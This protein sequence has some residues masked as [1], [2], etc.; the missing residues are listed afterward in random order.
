MRMKRVCFHKLSVK[1]LALS[2]VLFFPLR[3]FAVGWTPSDAGLVVDLQLGDRILVSVMADP[4]G[5]G[6]PTEY[7]LSNYSAYTGGDYGY[8]AGDYMKLLPQA[9]GAVEPSPVTV[10]T[11][12]NL[13]PRVENSVDYALGGTA[14]SMWSSSNKTLVTT[15]DAYMFRG[16]LSD[17]ENKGSKSFFCDVVFVVP[18]IRATT[19]FDPNNT[20][21]HGAAFDGAT[22]VGFAGMVYREV[23]MFD[24]P[25]TNH[26]ITYTNSAMVTFNTANGNR[27]FNKTTVEKGKAYYIY[28][29]TKHDATP[30]TVFRLYILNNPHNYCPDSYFFAYN[31]QSYK[32]YRTGDPTQQPPTLMT[33]S[34]AGSKVYMMDRLECMEQDAVDGK[35]FKTRGMHVPMSDSVYYYVGNR[36]KYR[37]SGDAINLGS[38]TAVS[39]F[40]RI[41]TLLVDALKGE[42]TPFVAPHGAFGKMVVDTTSA[43]QNLGVTFE[44]AGYFLR[45]NTGMNVPMHKADDGSWICDEMWTIDTAYYALSIKATL[46]SGPTFSEMDEGVDIEGWSEMQSGSEIRVQRTGEDVLNKSGWA[47]IEPGNAAKNGGM[48]FVLADATKSI[49]YDYNGYI[50][51]PLPDQYPI[52]GELT[53]KVR[54]ARLASGFTFLSWNTAADGSGAEYMPGDNFTLTGKDTLYAQAEFNENMHI[55]ISFI[56]SADS[57]RY[58]LT[59]PNSSVPRFARARHFE[60]W[61]NVRQGM[62]GPENSDPN[63]LSTFAMVDGCLMC[64]PNDRGLDPIRDTMY[65][66]Q[67]SLIYYEDYTPHGSEYLGLYYAEPNTV[68]ANNT[69]AGMFGS[70]AG[71]PNFR[72]PDIAS[73]K[74]YSERYVQ[75]ITPPPTDGPPI[76]LNT[77]E[78]EKYPPYVK[79]D[80]ATNQFN[81]V[82]EAEATEFQ[83]SAVS[84]ADAHYVILPDTTEAWRD[85]LTFGYHMN[86]QVGERV[87]SRLIGKQLMACTMVGSDTVYFHPNKNKTITD[88]NGLRLSLDYRISESFTLIPDSRVASLPGLRADD[89]VMMIDEEYNDFSRVI[90]CGVSSPKDV[91]YKG[92]Y[93][94]IY[95][96]LRIHLRPMGTSKIKE[97]YGRWKTGAEGLHV[98]EDGSRYRDVIICTKTYHY[99]P[100]E[101]KLVLKPEQESYNFSPLADQSLQ[102]NFK[103]FEVTSHWLL[104]KDGNRIVEEEISSVDVT[105]EKLMLGPGY[106]TLS[107]GDKFEV[108]ST[109]TVND[110]VVIKTRTDNDDPGE[111]RAELLVSVTIGDKADSVQVRVPLHQPALVGNDLIWSAEYN[112]QRYF[113]LASDTGLVFRQYRLNNN[114][115]YKLNTSTHLKVGSKDAKNSDI[116]YITQWEYTYTG[117]PNQLTLHAGDPINTYF[118]VSGDKPTVGASAAVLTWVYD[119]VN[120]NDNANFEE[121]VRL[122]YGADKWLAFNVVSGTPKLTL[123]NDSASASIF[124]WGYLQL[125]YSLMNNGAYPSQESAVFSFDHTSNVTIQTRYKAYKEYSILL[126]NKINYLGRV[127]QTRI[128]SLTSESREW[129]TNYAITLKR[130]GRTGAGSSGISISTDASTLTTTVSHAGAI[131]IYGETEG[132][133][134]DIVDILDVRISLQDGAKDYRFKDAWRNYTSLEDAHLEI[135]LI[136]KTYHNVAYDSL[137]CRVDNDEYNYTFPI[138]P[139]DDDTLHTF[140]LHTERHYG[141]HVVD[142][143]GNVQYVSADGTADLTSTM[144]FTDADKGE[145]RLTDAANGTPS[146]CS[147]YRTTANTITVKCKADAIR[148]PRTAY[149]YLAYYVNDGSSD[150]L[151]SF[152][153]SISQPSMFDYGYNQKLVHSR[154]ASGDP[155]MNGMQQVHENK[156]ILYY[157]NTP[158]DPSEDPD[159]AVELP[160]RER[161]FFGWWRWFREGGAD[162][163]DTDIPDALWITP[164]RNVDPKYNFPFRTIGDSVW[165]DKDDEL[166]G[167]KLVTMGR[168]TVF[169]YPSREYTNAKNDPPAKTPTVVPPYDKSVV[170]YAV[171]LSN[172]YDN[173]PLQM[174]QVNQVDWTMLDTMSSIVEPTLSL[175]EV[176]ELHPWTEMAEKM[177][178]YKYLYTSTD[179]NDK[180]MED[181]VVMAPTGNAL[182][183][184]TEHRY[185]YTNLQNGG[186]SESLLCYY[187]RDDNWATWAGNTGRQD[188]MV[189]VAG[190]DAEAKWYTYTPTTGYTACNYKLTTGDDFLQVPAKSSITSGKESDTI[191]YC[192]RARSKRT[193]GTLEKDFSD[194]KSV[195]GDSVYNICRY[196]VI[197]HYP[198]KYGPLQETTTRGVT[199]A[200]I[201][202][203]EI[204]KN[205]EV[206]ERLNF[207]YNRPGK[208]Y[209]VYPHPLPWGDASYGYSYPMTPELPDNRHHNDF[210][211]NFPN[212][213]EYG[214]I[215]RIP[216]SKF[217]HMME[218]HGGAENGYM[219]YCDGMS[220]AG[221]V[222]AISLNTKLCEGQ[223]MYF[224]GYVGNPSNQENSNKAKPNFLFSVQG[225]KDGDADWTDITSYMTGDIPPSNKWSQIFF[226]ISSETKFDHYRVRVMNMASSFDGNDFI[227]DDMCIFATKT[228]LIAYQA[229]S[230]CL[231]E[232]ESESLSHVVLRIDYQ[233]FQDSTTFNNKDV[234]Y[235]VEQMTK[236]S[237][238]SYVR[239]DDGY[240]NEGTTKEGMVYGSIRM[241]ARSHEPAHEDSIYTNLTDMITMFDATK[242][243][244][245]K[246]RQ[247]YIFENLDGQVRPVLYVVHQASVT[248]A[249]TY[250]VRMAASVSELTSS[251][252]AMTSDMKVSNRMAL[253]LNGEE[254]PEKILGGQCANATYDLSLRVKGSLLIDSVAPVDINGS[255]VNDWLL[256]GDTSDVTSSVR[257]GYKYSDIKKIIKILRADSINIRTRNANQFARNL[258]EVSRADMEK[259]EDILNL[260]LSSG[261]NA[262]DALTS[263]VNNGFLTLYQSKVTATAPYGDSIVYVIFPI[264]GTGSDAMLDMDIE[265]CPTPV[266]VK[267][268]TD[269]GMTER[270][271]V[272][273]GE[274]RGGIQEPFG[275]LAGAQEANTRIRIP[276]ESIPSSVALDTIILLSTNDPNYL[277]EIHMLS[278]LPDKVWIPGITTDRDAYYKDGDIIQLD[279]NPNN[280]YR[281]QPGYKY[282]F[283]IVMQT[284]GGSRTFESTSCEV[285]TI[286]FTV[287]VVPDYLRWDPKTDDSNQWNNPDN[288][289]G[290]TQQNAPIHEDAHFVPLPNT[291]VVIAPLAEGLPYPE[292]ADSASYEKTSAQNQ[293]GFRFNTCDSIRFMPGT[294]MRDQQ[295]LTYNGA[296]VDM[297]TPQDKWALR[298]APVMGMLSG[299]VFMSNADLSWGTTPWEVGEFDAN[300]RNYTTGNASFWLSLYRSESIHKGNGDNVKDDTT[301]TA[302]AEW[303][304]VTNSMQY[305]LKPAQGWAVYTHTAS[306]RDAVVR[307]PKNDDIY[308]YY[309]ADGE[310]MT[311][312]YEQYVRAKRASDAGGANKAGRL[313]FNPD[314]A[315][316]TYTLTNGAASTSFV[317]GNPT[318]G[319]IDIWGF[320]ADN[321]L[322]EEF[323]YIEEGAEIGDQYTT[324][325][326]GALPSSSDVITNPARYLPPMR[327]IV[328]NVSSASTSK[329]ITLNKNRVITSV[330]QVVRDP[331][332]APSR[333]S[334]T[335]LSKGIMTITAINPVST[336]CTSRLL[337]GQGFHNAVREG[338]DAMLTTINIDHY[339]TTSAPATPFNIYA[340][341]GNYGLSIDLRD[342]VVNVPISFY[343]SELPFAPTTQLWFT[344]VS[345]IDGELVLYD[346]LTGTERLLIDGICLEIPTPEYSHQT[347]YY[348]R[349]R[350]YDPDDTTGPIA[351]DVKIFETDDESAV[352]IIKD[353]HVL[354]LR[355][356]HVYTLFGQKIQ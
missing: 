29:D 115:L 35:I 330:S 314:G 52:E 44:P 143:D 68:I 248:P 157:Y 348:I 95:D 303:A 147:I 152:R 324:I 264:V 202:N 251:I 255:C 279:P 7:F 345:N 14:Y 87:W 187:M 211:S 265:V 165:I 218:Q 325:T 30:R 344:G 17:T 190:W 263:L 60:D 281:M 58:F 221:Q 226:P 2:F 172:Y 126:A 84:V 351:T 108:S 277:E 20:L 50:G 150:R 216:Y 161:G 113:I 31:E 243:S 78:N 125:E 106:C 72:T 179:K 315:A 231:S 210:A 153:L 23:Y 32:K 329:S 274:S 169:H 225:K 227:I 253:E 284:V 327:A 261:V 132:P 138:H 197:Y 205:Y 54:D 196:K 11:I 124:S 76:I 287:S 168:Y 175:R 28:A 296:V 156:R 275:I 38:D 272:L 283:G 311:E 66:G 240:F 86:E 280:T 59:H 96:T 273:H 246:F 97:Y 249:N 107:S 155:L 353:G 151:V 306:E 260:E 299:D 346:A 236:D 206:L 250:T 184:R 8:T 318:M 282:T 112:G 192:L 121:R 91:Q 135:P 15:G 214:L 209:Q 104:D 185:N 80:P 258:S 63:Y 118:A 332:P 181:H 56:N 48:S 292:L 57:M 77:R 237:V 10:W 352:K 82:V 51:S 340:A 213:G 288:W 140:V 295:L 100:T 320:I 170:T 223:K 291:S 268:K 204:E 141:S 257:Y 234:Y 278:L 102:L 286:P 43:E 203:E 62:S 338:E 254:Q 134:F 266:F 71:W 323:S 316:A 339:S 271:L 146:W 267:L 322:V 215:N 188:S 26:P 317:F 133:D 37:N 183:L 285:G 200:L 73:T 103:L 319:Y 25:R 81:G 182:L 130:D 127:E 233:G 53:V 149:I 40:K 41:N 160:I 39:Q 217:W 313:A 120:V 36:N 137:L 342:E 186:H 355:N 74:L 293:M 195:D 298:S 289:I 27:T 336:R 75:F 94:D 302:A 245:V 270:P 328:V 90:V 347:R 354:I 64:D 356:G 61:T 349:R 122:K 208:D 167:K 224:S 276:I 88:A 18:T 242:D 114:I 13:F 101:T 201:T 34:T 290:I 312:I 220:S 3:L 24:I 159:Q 301:R 230:S 235:T 244:E 16:N 262:Y 252:C 46:Y 79:Y 92:K 193:T 21:G 238:I 333:S 307:L 89:K 142:V 144:D 22:G 6:T 129:K 163:G 331:A 171:D 19:N 173:L 131:P 162:V 99:G 241:P 9:S 176:F 12:D 294:S 33:D 148:S 304:R 229:N 174:S 93:V 199:K 55:A 45:T 326:K 219:I 341:E 65:V 247:G 47:R 158:T 198:Q 83:L 116:Q 139:E 256:Y 111:N 269:V 189:W 123:V 154:G 335:G 178:E 305:S 259:V 310:K 128:D 207:D 337:L 334:A 4:D 117:T 180:Y 166:L 309:N 1:I 177:Q 321:G 136:R 350:G 67:D 5:D 119:V 70:T 297:Q 343:M 98:L 300:G 239:M 212:M 145:L 109:A 69:W 85:T 164:P 110:H 105:T 42:A 308:Y 232:T 49:H 228:P 222:A 191:Y 194:D